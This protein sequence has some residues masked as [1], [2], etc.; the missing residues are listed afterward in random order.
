MEDESETSN[1]KYLDYI[2]NDLERSKA[3]VDL[4]GG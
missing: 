1:K 3:G 2:K 4:K